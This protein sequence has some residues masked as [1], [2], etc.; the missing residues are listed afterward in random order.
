[1]PSSLCYWDTSRAHNGSARLFHTT[2]SSAVCSSEAS[3]SGLPILASLTHS[4]PIGTKSRESIYRA[5]VWDSAEQAAEARRVADHLACVAWSQRMLAFP[6][7]GAA[8]SDPR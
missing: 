6:G 4:C 1:M 2:I 7:T 8:L 3:R 5:S